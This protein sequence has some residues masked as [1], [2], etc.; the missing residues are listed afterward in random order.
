MLNE[1]IT[2]TR[3]DGTGT[4]TLPTPKVGEKFMKLVYG[5]RKDVTV[6][7]RKIGFRKTGNVNRRLA[8][9]LDITPYLPPELEE[10]R[11]EILAQLNISFHADKLQFG[12]FY[13]DPTDKPTASRRFSSEYQLSHRDKGVGRVWIEYAHKLIRVQVNDDFKTAYSQILSSI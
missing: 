5:K 7:G 6:N 1:G 12:I 2:N 4:L 9:E 11:E 13:R 10:E 8:K 3:N